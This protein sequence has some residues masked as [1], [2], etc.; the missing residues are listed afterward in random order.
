VTYL[1]SALERANIPVWDYIQ[2]SRD[3]QKALAH[4]IEQAIVESSGV[5]CVV[6]EN[7]RNSDWVLREYLYARELKKPTFLLQFE[8]ITPTLVISERTLIDFMSDRAGGLRQ[9][10]REIEEM[11]Q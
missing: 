1:R 11:R 5:L 6:T 2:G 3:F 9:L 8:P 4:E 7:W 10:E